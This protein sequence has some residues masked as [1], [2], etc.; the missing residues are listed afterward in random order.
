MTTVRTSED[1]GVGAANT[2]IHWM[3]NEKACVTSHSSMIITVDMFKKARVRSHSS[4]F[5]IV[6]MFKKASV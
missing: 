6:D 4:M 1:L 5:I 2:T 3:D